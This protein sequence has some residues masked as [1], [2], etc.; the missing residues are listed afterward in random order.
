MKGVIIA[1]GK[2]TRLRPL[3]CQIPK[4]LV[5]LVRKPVMEHI[6][7]WLKRFGITEIAVTLQYLGEK[8]KDYFG[9]GSHWGVTITYFEEEKPLGTAGS[10]KN[11]ASYFD[12]TFVVVSGDILT[13]FDLDEA[14]QFHYHKEAI[15]TVLMTQEAEPL[16]YGEILTSHEGKI[17]R[18]IEKPKWDEVYSDFVNTG[19]YILE[20]NILNYIPENQYWDFSSDLFPLLLEKKE[21]LYGFLAKGYWSD[22]GTIEQYYKSHHDILNQKVNV[23]INGQ[24]AWTNVWVG[25]N[26]EIEEGANIVGP[27]FIGDGAVI[28]KNATVGPYS[29]VGAH[30]QICEDVSVKRSILWD[31]VYV[32]KDSRLRGSIIANSTHLDRNVEILDLSVIGSH[33]SM[34]KNVRVKPSVKIWPEKTIIEGSV[35]NT[36]VVWERNSRKLLFRKDGISGTANIDITPDFISKVAVAYGSS[37]PYGSKIIVARDSHPFSNLCKEVFIQSVRTAGVHVVECSEIATIPVVRYQLSRQSYDGGIFFYFNENEQEVCI[38]FYD[39]DGY[40]IDDTKERKIEC[41]WATEDYRRA[42][43]ERI[44]TLEQNHQF[45][46]QYLLALQKM[47]YVQSSNRFKIVAVCGRDLQEWIKRLGRWLNCEI[48]F[49]NRTK[50]TQDIINLLQS[51]HANFAFIIH[52]NG[53]QFTLIDEQGNILSDEQLWSIYIMV[54]FLLRSKNCVPI[55]NY[56]SSALDI[57]ASRLNGEVVR[58]KGNR[59]S[60]LRD[61]NDSFHFCF[62]A[63]YAFTQVVQLLSLEYCSLSQLV[64]QIPHIH[65]L[66]DNVT[67][68]WS[69]R[70][71][72][73][74]KLIEETFEKKVDF[75]DG[76]KVYHADGGWTLILP[77][78]DEPIFK[79][80]SQADNLH[81]ARETAMYYIKKIRQYQNV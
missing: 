55:P 12:D 28:R 78:L 43:L 71:F 76:M 50:E 52:N 67:C 2:G 9:D 13:D 69:V 42:P 80:Y 11:A 63:L 26:V 30:V 74:R 36:S 29:V 65:M 8:I 70:G 51:V 25:R 64:A 34:K 22:I 61:L 72:V 10:I 6:I 62:D 3:T 59:S 44:G 7:E 58:T 79:I 27:V 60:L 81:K 38:D 17:E 23:S 48:I 73:M 45:V 32:G 49:V 16:D 47:I 37:L 46:L 57:L 39:K 33:C 18:I 20:P 14:I 35:V 40:P 24:E 1:G 41:I 21:R 66:R 77:G 31:H 19:I 5:P 53:E 68:P 56:V 4:P 75:I 54:T 15:A